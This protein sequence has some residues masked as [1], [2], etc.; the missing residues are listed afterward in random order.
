MCEKME[1]EN[2]IVRIAYAQTVQNFVDDADFSW[3]GECSDE[4]VHELQIYLRE[5]GIKYPKIP[6]GKRGEDVKKVLCR[7]WAS[8][9]CLS[10]MCGLLGE[11]ES[12]GQ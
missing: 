10:L 11:D 9:E 5:K 2:P 8:I 6:A 4:E 12:N 3:D 1:Q 7:T